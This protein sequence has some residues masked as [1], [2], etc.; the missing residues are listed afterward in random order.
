M[1]KNLLLY[2]ILCELYSSENLAWKWEFFHLSSTTLETKHFSHIFLA[3]DIT[4]RK[5]GI[6]QES[7]NMRLSSLV[8][9]M[10]FTNV[11]L[12][13]FSVTVL[14]LVYYCKEEALLSSFPNKISRN[15]KAAK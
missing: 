5:L 8:Q 13:D 7:W 9:K 11:N 6:T 1:L 4:E 12:A 2:Y 10:I 14:R 15:G 3:A